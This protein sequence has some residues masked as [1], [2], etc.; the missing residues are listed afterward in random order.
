[1]ADTPK[2]KPEKTHS[3]EEK[4]T[5]SSAPNQPETKPAKEDTS[6][7]KT[8]SST[9]EK[10]ELKASSESKPSNEKSA[11]QKPK[12]EL[13]QWAEKAFAAMKPEELPTIYLSRFGIK[14]AMDL[15]KF[16]KSPAGETVIAE[17]KAQIAQ[18]EN[19]E[20]QQRFEQQEHRLLVSRIKAFLLFLFLAK[21]AYASD[22]VKEI[23]ESQNEKVLKPTHKPESTSVSSAPEREKAL[24]EMM[25][26]YNDALKA[27]EQNS[28]DAQ[29][30]LQE[31]KIAGEQIET[32][33]Q[34]Y[35]TSLNQVDEEIKSDAFGP[36]QVESR[37]VDLNNQMKYGAEN[38]NKLLSAKDESGARTLLHQQTALNLQL[39]TL[40]DIRAVH[41]GDKYYANAMGG[42][43]QSY[44]DAAFIL[45]KDQKI[46]VHTEGGT[47]KCY[48]VK[49]NETLDSLR[50][51][52]GA[53]EAAESAYE[54]NK[55]QHMIVRKVVHHNKGI[56]TNEHRTKVDVANQ[57]IQESAEQ[58][59]L[60]TNQMAMLQAMRGSALNA[61]EGMEAPRPVPTPTPTTTSQK[62]TQAA[63]TILHR[64]RLVEIKNPPLTREDLQNLGSLIPEPQLREKFNQEYNKNIPRQGPI[65][66]LKMQHMLKT[67]EQFGIDTTKP[68]VTSIRNPLELQQDAATAPTPF[69]TK[70]KLTPMG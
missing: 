66:P 38:I 44:K 29:K 58:K 34:D 63:A 3:P 65:P 33:Y 31:L 4:Q 26:R 60:I 47:T 22:K 5:I 15:K 23:I 52:P 17:I 40:M 68:G 48:L 70:P 16:L 56:E 20:A 49:E 45:P 46:L 7:K 51:T 1:M 59:R 69:S 53:L 10:I 67:L 64:D 12:T 32:R 42:Q 8:K 39:A 11:P 37:I 6:S 2:V 43:E 24:Q 41:R 27:A 57:I 25:T 54:A 50:Q 18:N 30:Q 9:D 14:T 13:D 61:S 62:P 19:I 36:A 28:I 55:G 35:D 21:E